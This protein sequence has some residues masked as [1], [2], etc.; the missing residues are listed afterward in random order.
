MNKKIEEL[1]EVELKALAFEHT[2]QLEHSQNAIVTIKNEL[3]KR[4]QEAPAPNAPVA[5]M[6]SVPKKK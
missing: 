5:V 1:S 3:L 2:L 6:E 4:Q